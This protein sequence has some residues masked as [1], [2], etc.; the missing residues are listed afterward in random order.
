M[1]SGRPEAHGAIPDKQDDSIRE[2]L[3]LNSDDS[4]KFYIEVCQGINDIAE[5]CSSL[6]IGPIY[7][8]KEY[9]VAYNNHRVQRAF[10]AILEKAAG[11]K[12][13]AHL[14]WIQKHDTKTGIAI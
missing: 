3:R 1:E 12:N 2:K 8:K 10:S 9:V 11:R 13:R 5:Y 14:S 7:K 4:I 6:S